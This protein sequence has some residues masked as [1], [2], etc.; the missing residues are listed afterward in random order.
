MVISFQNGR[1]KCF[2]SFLEGLLAKCGQ[3]SSAPLRSFLAAQCCPGHV[4][5]PVVV[6]LLRSRLGPW[7]KWKVLVVEVFS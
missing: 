5:V 3:A 6:G 7:C 2:K 1:T 4:S